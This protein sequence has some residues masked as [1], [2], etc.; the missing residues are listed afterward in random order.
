MFNLF[1][2]Y[3]LEQEITHIGLLGDIFDLMIGPHLEFY[4]DFKPAF[5]LI[6]EGLR[7]GIKIYYLE[8]NHDFHLEGFFR[9][10]GFTKFPNFTYS[11]GATSIQFGHKI[12]YI[13]HGD[14]LGNSSLGYNIYS[15]FILRGRFVSLLAKIAPYRLVTGIGHFWSNHSRMNKKQK[16]LNDDVI[17]Q[18]FRD[19]TQQF[20]TKKK[21]DVLII[22]HS[23]LQDSFALSQGAIVLN[24][25]NPAN[26]R[27]CAY[28]DAQRAALIAFA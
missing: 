14:D 9:L 11:K 23:H 6:R 25:G 27:L 28:V 10:I 1:L 17:R 8:G 24:N 19:A 2:N 4:H 15:R 22:G 13:S 26:T 18:K 12:L 16:H 3:C 5:E 21:F 7:K 20:W